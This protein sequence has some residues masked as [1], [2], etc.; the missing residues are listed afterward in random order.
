MCGCFFWKKKKGKIVE[1]K[2]NLSKNSMDNAI[3]GDITPGMSPTVLVNDNNKIVAQNILWGFALSERKLLI[4]A[5]AETALEK[6]LF[7][8]S[9]KRQRCVIPAISFYE[10]DK[11][12][13]KATFSKK[14]G[15]I[16]Y[17]AGFFLKTND[18]NSFIILTTEAN[19]SVL[20]IHHRMPL[21]LDNLQAQNWLSS[22]NIEQM[23]K[24][25]M[26]D[27]NCFQKIKQLSFEEFL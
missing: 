2:F 24:L 27:L 1:E 11:N 5:R 10:W 12:K 21:I 14:N 19:N 17:F 20:P 7:R 9:L 23:L 18:K 15:S 22:S 8:S 6:V 3:E 26:P 25:K 16:L 4:N 13:I